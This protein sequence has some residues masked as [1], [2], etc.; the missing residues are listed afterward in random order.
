MRKKLNVGIITGGNVAERGISLKSGKTIFDHLDKEKYNAFLIDFDGENFTE[1]ESGAKLRKKDFTFK[2]KKKR[3]NIDLAF[4]MLHGHPAEDGVLQ[5]YL[6]IIGI[7]YT[8]CDHFISGLTFDKQNCK[9]FLK[10]YNIPM[11][12]SMLIRKGDEIDFDAIEEMGY[13]LFVKPNKN[14]SS[15]GISKVNDNSCIRTSIEKSFQFDDEVIIESFLKGREFSNGVFRKGKE[16]IVLP[17]T[18]IIS[19]NEFFDYEAKYENASDEVTPADLT[20]E[21]MTTCKAL[22]RKLY[23][24]LN[25]KGMVRFDTI[26]MDGIFYF[27]EANTIPGFSEQSLFPQ[28]IIA[29]GM[30]IQEVLDDVVAERLTE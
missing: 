23:E 19:E 28:Q 17:V 29:H 8:G 4:L 22:S 14:G 10:H 16:I 1:I 9:V 11:A 20:E 5:G 27:L 6:D 12:A 2:P 3:K 25:C 24:V 18:E 13:P 15:Y 21:E 7:P 30:T 26:K